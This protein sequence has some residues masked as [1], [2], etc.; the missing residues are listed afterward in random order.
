[1]I[2]IT[3]IYFHAAENALHSSLITAEFIIMVGVLV[4]VRGTLLTTSDYTAPTNAEIQI[5][6][7]LW[8][9]IYI[10]ISKIVVVLITFIYFSTT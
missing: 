10:C 4:F 2:K 5:I 8:L 3:I 1:M 9:S 7:K 6:R